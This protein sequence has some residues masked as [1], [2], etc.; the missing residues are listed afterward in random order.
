MAAA[1]L[2]LMVLEPSPPVPQVSTSVPLTEGSMRMADS[3]IFLANPAISDTDSPFLRNA[4]RTAPIMAS[5]ALLNI[6]SIR[7]SD[8][9]WDRSCP[10]MIF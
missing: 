5:D 3:R 6:S 8:S 2:T 10:S 9:S 4:T 1:V 7:A